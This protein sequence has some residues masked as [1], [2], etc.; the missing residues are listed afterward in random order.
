MLETGSGF[1]AAHYNYI[2]NYNNN[3]NSNYIHNYIYNYNYCCFGSA[4]IT[5]EISSHGVIR[6]RT[7]RHNLLLPH[8]LEMFFAR[9]TQ[10][11]WK[12]T[13]HRGRL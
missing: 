9:D 2:Y 4:I 3:Y 10:W 5:G 7:Y 1:I 13:R 6:D 11:K 8:A 12:G